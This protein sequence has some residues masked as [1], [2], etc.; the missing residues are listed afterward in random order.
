MAPVK[1]SVVDEQSAES[2][3]TARDILRARHHFDIH[4]EVGGT[5]CGEGYDSRIGNQ[6]YTCL[7]GD[8]G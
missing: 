2:C 1:A 4:A 8:V 3:S 6:G 5:E 7:M